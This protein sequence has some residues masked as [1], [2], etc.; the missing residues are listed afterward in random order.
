MTG[1]AVGAGESGFDAIAGATS[2]A[3]GGGTFAV[4]GIG[5]AAEIV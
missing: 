2:A 1:A 4:S 3:D 5:T